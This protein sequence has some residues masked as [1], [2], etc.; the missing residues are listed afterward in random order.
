[1]K[2]IFGITGIV[3]ALAATLPSAVDLRLTDL[4]DPRDG[5]LALAPSSPIPEPNAFDALVRAGATL[6]DR[7]V[8]QRVDAE[9]REQLAAT[10]FD[11]GAAAALIAAHGEAL[12]HFE[13]ALAA[14]GFRMPEVAWDEDLPTVQNWFTVARLHALS[15]RLQFEREAGGPDD[16]RAGPAMRP[17]LELGQRIQGD[18]SATW[19]H[20]IAGAELKEIGLRTLIAATAT[21]RPTAG[22][23]HAWSRALADFATRPED[24][25]TAWAGEYR[26]A[27]AALLASAAEPS[28]GYSFQPNRTLSRKAA[29]TRALQAR[30]GRPCAEL[31]PEPES[32]ASPSPARLFLRGLQPNAVGE[33]LVEV[34]RPNANRFALRRCAS[35]TLLSATRLAIAI[36]AARHEGGGLPDSLTDLVPTYIEAIPAGAYDGT[37]LR[38]DADGPRLVAT[39]SALPEATVEQQAPHYDLPELPTA[40]AHAGGD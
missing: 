10:P 9:V 1:M 40:D 15:L 14:P 20:W 6:S 26:A 25:R 11:P 13:A 32:L 12:A 30:A 36:A 21:W 7:A 38:L 33:I 17:L 4:P 8:A 23:S 34:S 19:I 39:G 35:D 27:R 22:V 16:R 18:P 28:A 37:A 2:W 31:A 24:V 29:E 5:D 3:L